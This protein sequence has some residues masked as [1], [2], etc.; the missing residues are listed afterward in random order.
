MTAIAARE[1]TLAD[2]LA[3]AATRLRSPLL[4]STR[5]RTVDE[6]TALLVEMITMDP[7]LLLALGV[8]WQARREGAPR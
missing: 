6:A 1:L 8:V 5:A 4:E 2:A 3:E 7:H